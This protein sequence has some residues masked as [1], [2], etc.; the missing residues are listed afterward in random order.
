MLN[1]IKSIFSSPSSVEE[2]TISSTETNSSTPSSKSENKESNIILESSGYEDDDYIIPRKHLKR[3]QEREIHILEINEINYKFHD[4]KHELTNAPCTSSQTSVY[5]NNNMYIFGGRSDLNDVFKYNMYTNEMV[6][7]L[8]KGTA[9]SI[10][11]YHSMNL[12]YKRKKFYL[13]G[14]VSTKSSG[15]YYNELFQFDLV[16]NEWSEVKGDFKNTNEITD[17]EKYHATLG[18]KYPELYKKTSSVPSRSGHAGIYRSSDDCLVLFG[19]IKNGTKSGDITVYSFKENIWYEYTP[20]G[21]QQITPRSYHNGQYCKV[22]D[23][24]VIFG[25]D[26]SSSLSGDTFVLNFKANT[27]RKIENLTVTFPKVFGHASI[28]IYLP[29][30]KQNYIFSYGGTSNGVLDICYL[31]DCLEDK[32]YCLN[33]NTNNKNSNH[34]NEINFPKLN[35]CCIGFY[36]DSIYLYGGR[37][38]NN[39]KSNKMYKLRLSMPCTILQYF[40]KLNTILEDFSK[41]SD[42]DITIL[43]EL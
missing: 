10:R 19:G 25:G 36:N 8:T 9:P 2:S 35:C 12:D 32:W 28:P 38:Y 29:T 42:I 22:T 16:N 20:I 31:F 3:E 14:G 13:F 26:T 30:S 39:N 21:A 41:L 40:P 18:D 1:K 33:N 17:L 34:N 7:L 11:L 5:Y 4:E 23:E 37:D 15:Q 6:R 43:N 24:F 27:W